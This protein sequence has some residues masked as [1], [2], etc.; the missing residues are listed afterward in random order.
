MIKIRHT[1][2]VT[3]DLKK[4]LKFWTKYLKFKI[5]KEMDED[6][7]LI[8]KIMLYQNVKVKTHK[9]VDNNNM[10]LELLYFKNSPK[11][12]N[13]KIKPY[14]NGF[15]HISVTVKNLN[16]LYKFLKKNK[17]KFN[18]KPQVSIDG[19]VLMTYCR[20]PEGAFLELVEELK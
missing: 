11:I 8:D 18:S 17:I 14:T 3:N 2:L 15:T 12:K 7:D 10:L 9:L 4:S 13:N 20:T 16:N 19:N 6:G 1:G 5:K